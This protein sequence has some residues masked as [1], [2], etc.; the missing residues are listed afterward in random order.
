MFRTT[1]A[2]K[3]PTTGD[4]V[5]YHQDI[6]FCPDTCEDD[7]WRLK[8]LSSQTN[9]TL[10]KKGPAEFFVEKEVPTFVK[11]ET[12][13]ENS[14]VVQ[15]MAQKALA[16]NLK[17]PISTTAKLPAFRST[18]D[19][20]GAALDQQLQHG[21]VSAGRNLLAPDSYI[22]ADEAIGGESANM[23]R[24]IYLIGTT[25]INQEHRAN[26]VWRGIRAIAEKSG[27]PDWASYQEMGVGELLL[28][29][30]KEADRS[31]LLDADDKKLIGQHILGVAQVRQNIVAQMEML[32]QE[33]SDSQ[34]DE[35]QLYKQILTRLKYGVILPSGTKN[36]ESPLDM[37]AGR[38][39]G[40]WR[41]P[42]RGIA[43]GIS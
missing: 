35:Q 36:N 43:A 32:R 12:T 6:I 18:L 19:E 14:G 10:Y 15:S 27:L 8:R 4:V 34:S 24:N 9:K 21:G 23:A 16:I 1:Q 41:G 40:A 3:H 33:H 5:S 26:D 30:L 17:R 25:T 37:T 42:A 31:D 11:Y 28:G 13:K 7:T 39:I 20:I 22:P 29:V 38:G 2:D